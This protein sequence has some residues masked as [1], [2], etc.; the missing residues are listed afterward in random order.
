MSQY[1]RHQQ[2]LRCARL[3]PRRMTPAGRFWAGYL[4]CALLVVAWWLS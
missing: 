3:Y 4:L 1:L 2:I